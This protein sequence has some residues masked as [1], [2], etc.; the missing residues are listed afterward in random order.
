MLPAGWAASRLGFRADFAELLPEN[1]DSV[2]EMRRVSER[3]LG[4]FDILTIVAQIEGQGDAAALQGLSTPLFRVYA[5]SARNGPER[6]MTECAR[7][8]CS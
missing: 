1:K 6:S 2:I 7:H 4:T 5:N 8:E 3:L